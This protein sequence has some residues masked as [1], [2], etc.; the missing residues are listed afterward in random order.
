MTDLMFLGTGL[1]K[2]FE[3]KQE[4]Y[5][6]KDMDTLAKEKAEGEVACEYLQTFENL[7]QANADMKIRICNKLK[8]HYSTI[9]D[10]KSFESLQS[11]LE[12]QSLDA[13]ASAEAVGGI[14]NSKGDKAKIDSGKLGE[15]KQNF[16]AKAWEVIKTAF[17]KIYKWI[18]EKIEQ[19]VNWI[20]NLFNKD[21]GNSP[22]T[23]YNDMS[24]SEVDEL[25]SAIST[26]EFEDQSEEGGYIPMTRA[27]GAKFTESTNKY[28]KI[29][30]QFVALMNECIS[31]GYKPEG[32]ITYIN[33]LIGVLQQNMHGIGTLPKIENANPEQIKKFNREV[34]TAA[35][36]LTWKHDPVGYTKFFC[37]TSFIEAKGKKIT[38]QE[39][40]GTKNPIEII[41]IARD[42]GK[43]FEAA[44]S[45]VKAAFDK[46]DQASEKFS[47]FLSKMNLSSG[48]IKSGNFQLNE[49]GNNVSDESKAD[50]EK[51]YEFL[52]TVQAFYNIIAKIQTIIGAIAAKATSTT[53]KAKEILN[54]KT[55]IKKGL[56]DAGKN[57]KDGAKNAYN[58]TVKGAKETYDNVKEALADAKRLREEAKKARQE[59][60][61]AKA[62]EKAAKRAEAERLEAEAKKA[63]A[64]AQKRAENKAR[65]A[66]EKEKAESDQYWQNIR[67]TNLAKDAR[68]YRI[69]KPLVSFDTYMKERGYSDSEIAKAHSMQSWDPDDLMFINAFNV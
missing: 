49:Q 59:E 50:A 11:F 4:K 23:F 40:Y 33:T 48:S 19:F 18:S 25:E 17:R 20:K 13:G 35:Q 3:I 45:N 43:E 31:T 51:N 65:K 6:E 62:E 7:A 64:A 29:C 46:V 38:C 22:E 9:Q 24:D 1:D 2:S 5:E 54:L 69:D 21:S 67:N 63:E 55:K 30:N 16:F 39:L 68:Q 34:K 10:D 61:K 60:K 44:R 15:Q 52:A 36:H 27:S 66:A 37:G 14:N 12:T 32:M 42:V 26:F 53:T 47:Q 28:V 41:K 57:I 8:A 58:S 56:K